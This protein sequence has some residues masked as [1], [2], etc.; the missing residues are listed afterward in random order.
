MQLRKVCNH[1]Q[2]FE[3]TADVSPFAMSSGAQNASWPEYVA[4]SS[5]ASELEYHLPRLIYDA[6]IDHASTLSIW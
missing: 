3:K 5:A 6:F 4:T 1:P 2:I